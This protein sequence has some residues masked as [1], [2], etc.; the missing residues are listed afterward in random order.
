[1]NNQLSTSTPDTPV[2]NSNS[3]TPSG[4]KRRINSSS[5]TND[6]HATPPPASSILVDAKE[7]DLCRNFTCGCKK[8]GGRPCSTQFTVDHFI[9]M[10]AQAS[11]LSNDE[12]DMVLLGSIMAMLNRSENIVDGRHKPKKRQRDY[13]DYTHNCLSVCA[14]TFGFLHG[15]GSKKRLQS[16]RSHYLENGMTPRVHGNTKSLPHNALPFDVI[17]AAV[18]FLQNYAEQHA[19]LLPGRIPEMTSSCYHQVAAKWCIHTQQVALYVTNA[20]ELSTFKN[21]KH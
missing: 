6:S 3:R 19:I 21:P 14:V 9:E 13:S 20:C 4:R 8:I 10:R 15:I 18:K 11:L 16:L 2:T 5:D 17:E 7:F 1:M 12:L